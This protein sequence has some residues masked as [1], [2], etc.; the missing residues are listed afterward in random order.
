MLFMAQILQ[1]KEYVYYENTSNLR[2]IFKMSVIG[3]TLEEDDDQKGAHFLAEVTQK[4][5]AAV[6]FR[7]R[8][9]R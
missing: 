1:S 4:T 3:D 7:N 5:K 8:P 9:E 2:H 6:C